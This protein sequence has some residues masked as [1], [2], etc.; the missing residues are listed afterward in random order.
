MKQKERLKWFC[1]EILRRKLSLDDFDDKLI[2]QK[3]VYI[4]QKLGMDFNYNFGWHV[5]GVYSSALTVDI[6]EINDQ[7]LEYS[8]SPKERE[9]AEKLLTIRNV[10]G[11][12][13]RTF[14]LIS[15]VMYAREDRGMKDSEITEFV[16]IVKPW[17]SEKEIERAIQESYKL[18]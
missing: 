4:A 18:N 13:S 9:I 5:R 14:E 7:D 6:Y 2:I 11:H 3:A 10:F 17:F 15:T 8:P 16:K 1:N 12:I